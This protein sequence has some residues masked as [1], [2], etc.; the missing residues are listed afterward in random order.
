M[1]MARLATLK[2]ELEG[3]RMKEGE[4]VDDFATKLT[5]LASKARSLGY[6]LEEVE[7]VKTLLDSM[8][9]SFLQIVASIA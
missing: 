4:M 9:K 1:R 6:E 2:R 8:P 3:L 7:L 5:G